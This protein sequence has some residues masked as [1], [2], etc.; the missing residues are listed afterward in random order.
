VP[1]RA[2]DGRLVRIWMRAAGLIVVTALL[3]SCAG[4]DGSAAL[5]TASPSRPGLERP[6]ATATATRSVD[7]P[8]RSLESSD[9]ATI[10]PTTTQ[11]ESA[12]AS[13]PATTSAPA[14]DSSADG[15]AP[16]W[17][18][19]LLGALVVAAGVAVP[20]VA[21][22]RR[23]GAWDGDLAAAE[24]EV[25]WFSRVLLPEL[26]QGGTAEHVRGGW[27][28]AEARVVAVED[29]L[30]TLQASAP[31]DV[32]RAR[33]RTLRDAVRSGGDRIRGLG[34]ADRVATLLEFDQVAATLEAALAQPTQT[35]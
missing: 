10:G 9:S 22:A 21:R 11:S 2:S 33:A 3:A 30:T 35:V 31:D 6:S 7:R 13:S 27:T 29:R 8:T 15:G 12:T 26:R 4:G 5:P 17:L 14:E 32:R 1:A 25:A 18:W 20:L 24:G 34:K 23:R 28:V 19:W 16:A